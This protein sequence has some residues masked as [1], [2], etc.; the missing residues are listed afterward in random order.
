MR[1]LNFIFGVLI[2]LFLAAFIVLFPALP[3]LLGVWGIICLVAIVMIIIG[4][5]F[6]LLRLF[7]IG[8]IWLWLLMGRNIFIGLGVGLLALALL[9]GFASKALPSVSVATNKTTIIS[10]SS[11]S[12]SIAV[13]D[14]A[15]EHGTYPQVQIGHPDF[16]VE[17]GTNATY[18][19]TFEVKPTEVGIVGGLVVDGQSGGVYRAYGPGKYTVQIQNGF[20][21]TTKS[22]WA[23][24]EFE[25]RIGQAIKYNWACGTV[26][27][28]PLTKSK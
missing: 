3:I 25:F 22:D 18:R 20:C 14:P 13:T 7:L 16:Y 24:N 2:V 15:L 27:Y 17:T 6:A 4:L 9:V 5:V 8:I 10:Q 19:W 26:D 23:Q 28:G 21:L 12:S 1:G 11:T